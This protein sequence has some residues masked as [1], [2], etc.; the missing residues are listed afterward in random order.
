MP[1]CPNGHESTLEL[2]CP[3]CGE[4]VLFGDTLRNL[5]TL[6]VSQYTFEDTA[7]LSVG[8]PPLA[9]PRSYSAL[10]RIQKEGSLR[11]DGFNVA[12][13]E[14][15]TWFDYRQKYLRE[16]KRWLRLVG[17]GKSRYKV[18]MVDSANPLSVLALT[19]L[20][21]EGNIAIFAV[22]ADD[23]STPLEQHTSYVALTEA[24]RKNVP[25]IWATNSFMEEASF[26]SEQKG[27]TMGQQALSQMLSFIFTPL[28]EF[29]DFVQRD[30]RLGIKAHGFSTLIAAS[31]AVY[32][33]VD[34]A[35]QVQC[36]QTSVNLDLEEVQSAYLVACAEE[37]LE[38]RILQGFK[39]YCTGHLVN[40]V[41][42]GQWFNA[43]PSRYRIYDLAIVYG[44]KNIDVYAR[45]RK[46]YE[47][48]ANQ[49]SDLN[50]ERLP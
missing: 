8:F 5:T 29:M 15:G 9:F 19:G 37:D 12:K 38:T 20:P 49:A 36:H 23:K 7:I 17:F 18:I 28:E 11:A 31:D 13:V 2:K 3:T 47:T 50:V 32:K 16:F 48:V 21:P 10:I 40:T 27:L 33:T 14:G 35:F 30:L 24:L 4:P 6:P 45:L 34:D 25:M 1:R 22:T 42:I 39:R 46:G 44:L 41:S 43:R 26:F